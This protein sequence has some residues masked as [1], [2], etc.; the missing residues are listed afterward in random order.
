MDAKELK[1]KLTSEG[2]EVVNVINA[3]SNGKVV[4]RYTG[5]DENSVWHNPKDGY[6]KMFAVLIEV[7]TE[8]RP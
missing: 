6:R 3:W 2:Y 8:E 5:Q 4:R 7:E 1:R